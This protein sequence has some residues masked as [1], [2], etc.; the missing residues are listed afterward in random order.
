MTPTELREAVNSLPLSKAK[1]A[2]KI[3][4]SPGALYNTLSLG[5]PLNKASVI[6]LRQLM[7]ECKTPGD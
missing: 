3:G 6:L 1:I 4:I 7:E 2:E 5:R